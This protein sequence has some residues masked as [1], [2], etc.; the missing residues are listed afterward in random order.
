MQ[1][2]LG[3]KAEAMDPSILEGLFI[4]QL[5][6]N[7]GMILASTAKGSNLLKLAEMA[8]S[9]MEV[10]S[11]SI[12][13]VATPQAT[14]LGELKVEVARLRRRLLDLEADGWHRSNRRTRCWSCSP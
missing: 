8:D 13:T 5:P 12:A 3:G 6:S 1:Q 7:I 4:Q 14:E 2:L 10:I 9:V 11:P